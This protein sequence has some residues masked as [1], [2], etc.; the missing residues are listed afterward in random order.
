M[1]D[2][3]EIPSDQQHSIFAGNQLE[4]AYALKVLGAVSLGTLGKLGTL[5]THGT[6]GT[7]HTWCTSHPYCPEMEWSGGNVVIMPL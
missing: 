6:A 7:W 4:N 2:K 5:G 1:Q 3:E